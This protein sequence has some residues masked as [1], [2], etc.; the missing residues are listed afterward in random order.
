MREH[1]YYR[2]RLCITQIISLSS[3]QKHTNSLTLISNSKYF[4]FLP[5]IPNY[6][7]ESK[8]Y[9]EIKISIEQFCTER[10][11]NYIND[12]V[13][14]NDPEKRA[15]KCN[16]GRSYLYDFNRWNRLKFK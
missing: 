3:D 8:K 7:S 13:V 14:D 12:T 15:I 6:I 11:I 5:L 1:N 4:I 9:A 10:S 2:C 16:S